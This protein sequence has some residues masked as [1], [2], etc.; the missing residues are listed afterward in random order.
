MVSKIFIIIIFLSIQLI[1]ADLSNNCISY[2]GAKFLYAE[3]QAELILVQN[4]STSD[5]VPCCELCLNSN[6]CNLFKIEYYKGVD[7]VCRLYKLAQSAFDNENYRRWVRKGDGKSSF[8][9]PYRA[10]NL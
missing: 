5:P 9:I 6:D 7:S 3:S 2:F 10:L 1:S 4:K 8:G